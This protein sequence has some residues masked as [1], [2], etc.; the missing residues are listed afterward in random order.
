MK[1]KDIRLHLLR[2]LFMFGVLIHH[3]RFV[4]R[5]NPNT[6]EWIDLLQKLSGG[7][8]VGF[9]AISGYLA[10]HSRHMTE[11]VRRRAVRLIVPYVACSTL[12]FVASTVVLAIYPI[13]A[14]G[15]DCRLFAK[16]LLLGQGYGPQYYYLFY[17]FCIEIGFHPAI[18]LGLTLHVFLLAFIAALVT[19]LACKMR[20][21]PVGPELSNVPCYCLSYLGGSLLRHRYCISR[22]KVTAMAAL[23]LT[24]LVVAGFSGQTYWLQVF[25]PIALW[26]LVYWIPSQQHQLSWLLALNPGAVYLWHTPIVMP[27]CS[28]I[29]ER[30]G[31]DEM[32]NCW[33]TILAAIVLSLLFDKLLSYIP[34]GRYVRL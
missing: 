25:S 4:S 17:L 19:T 29:L 34:Y 8:V 10:A 33:L 26:G 24:A 12:M 21:F 22:S 32:F 1:E 9:F 7:C 27:A 5:Y 15:A 2:W 13:T 18:K 6:L 11:F 30:I 3:S 23:V 14:G 20:I 28:V 16:N 31:I